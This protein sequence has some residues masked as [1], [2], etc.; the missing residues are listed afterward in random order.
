MSGTFKG[1]LVI[2]HNV[3]KLLRYMAWLFCL[4]H[5]LYD[6]IYYNTRNYYFSIYRPTARAVGG[7]EED[8]TV[9][10]TDTELDQ[11][12]VHHTTLRT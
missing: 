11:P 4:L 12:Y 1:M 5:H 3:Y 8:C 10:H 9:R 7:G 2:V 6:H